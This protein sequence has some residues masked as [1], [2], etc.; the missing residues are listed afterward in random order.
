MEPEKKKRVR[1]EGE[2]EKQLNRIIREGRKLF[3][4][5]GSEGLSM[6]TLAKKVDMGKSNLY[7]Y[8]QSKRELWFAIM[9]KDFKKFEEGMEELSRNHD[10]T[11]KELLLKT[12]RFYFDFAAEDKNRYKMM[13]LTPAPPS[14]SKGPLE[15]EYE[16][17]SI[18]FMYE[19]IQAAID[20]KEI[21]G[22]DS[23]KLTYFIWGIVHGVSSV[24]DTDLFGDSSRIPDYGKRE[25]YF[26]LAMQNIEK[27]LEII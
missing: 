12:A 2:K 7:T 3:L 23:G 27:I 4:K 18:Y 21:K 16:S 8:V 25:E 6:R 22:K 5:Y 15:K 10:G 24:I 19:L 1:S 11:Y 26:E 20:N 9:K 13:F 14:N 17:V